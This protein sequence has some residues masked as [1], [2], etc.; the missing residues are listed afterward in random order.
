MLNNCLK[1]V[2]SELLLCKQRRKICSINQQTAQPKFLVSCPQYYRC[3]N[4]K[5]FTNQGFF[6]TGTVALWDMLESFFLNIAD[7][8]RHRCRMFEQINSTFKMCFGMF[9]TFLTF[10][11]NPSRLPINKSWLALRRNTE[12]KVFNKSSRIILNKVKKQFRLFHSCFSPENDEWVFFL[13]WTG[14][15]I[16]LMLHKHTHTRYVSK[17]K[18]KFQAFIL[19]NE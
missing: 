11:W 3:L 16:T 4:L 5:I 1:L 2:G 7:L 18:N 12:I 14:F 15:L 17:S 10:W 8:C 9:G 19:E 13:S 6:L